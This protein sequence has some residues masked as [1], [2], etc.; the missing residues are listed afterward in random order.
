MFTL[1]EGGRRHEN[2]SK[3][4]EAAFLAPFFEAANKGGILTVEIS[5]GHLMPV[6]RLLPASK[7]YK[8]P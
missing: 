6:L 3:E 4:E 8:L 5:S 7:T 2:M 1:E